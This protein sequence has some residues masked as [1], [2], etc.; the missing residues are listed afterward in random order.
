MKII[1]S[2]SDEKSNSNLFKST[3]LDNET[4]PSYDDMNTHIQDK[5]SKK[6]VSPSYEMQTNENGHH[7]TMEV[8]VKPVQVVQQTRTLAQMREQLALK[9]KGLMKMARRTR[10]SFSLF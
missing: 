6:M 5:S 4:S 3:S 7:H 8:P 1:K 2:N 10:F 9:R